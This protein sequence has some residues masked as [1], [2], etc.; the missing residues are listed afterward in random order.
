M[1]SSPEPA[2]PAYRRPRMP[3]KHPQVLG[4]DLNRSES[5]RWA[6]RR[7]RRR[8]PNGTLWNIRGRTRYSA[9]MLAARITLAHFSVSSATSFPNSAGV[10]G[11]GSPPSSARRARNF[12]SANTAFTARFS[13]SPLSG[14]VPLGGRYP[15]AEAPFVAGHGFADGWHVRNRSHAFRPG[16]AE[17][18]HFSGPDV[19]NRTGNVVEQHLHLAGHQVG[20][21]GRRGPVRHMNKIDAG[22]YFE[23]LA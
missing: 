13:F 12:G 6:R 9:L 21:C 19:P 10:I 8:S 18:T 20:R 17:R 7:A 1:G 2:V 23:Q 15:V 4:V 11:M 5:S 22:H 3:R 14:G 16:H